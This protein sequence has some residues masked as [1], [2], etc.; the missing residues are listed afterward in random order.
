[1]ITIRFSDFWTLHLN[2]CEGVV[3]DGV[4]IFNNP[5]RLNSDGIDV[6]SCRNVHIS[7]CHVVAGDDAIHPKSEAGFPVENLVVTNCTL[8]STTTGLKIGTATAADFRN[9][10]FSNITI[11]APSGIGFY[12]KDGGVAENITFSNITIKTPPRTYRDV[13]PIFMDIE[14]RH[15]DSKLSHIRDVSFRD[16]YIESGSGILVQGM[17]ESRIENL[18]LYNIN[19][20]VGK[21][22]DYGK[23]TKPVGG[24]RTTKDERDTKYITMPSYMTVAYVKGLYIDGLRV[25]QSD[26]ARSAFERSALAIHESESVL[27]RGVRGAVPGGKLSL[28]FIDV[29]NTRDVVIHDAPSGDELKRFLRVQ[30]A[31]AGSLRLGQPVPVTR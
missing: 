14:R 22:D 2:R 26:A 9:V 27:I 13:V 23:R 5:R 31:P 29:G 20:R 24:Q 19:F 21:P 12:M 6:T 7:N 1:M 30:G 8:V 15:A 28:P 16:I 10:H 3:L 4:K 25:E 17:P 11:D 18:S